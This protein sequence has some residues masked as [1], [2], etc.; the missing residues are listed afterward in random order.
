MKILKIL[1]LTLFI[2]SCVTPYHAKV[3]QNK[4]DEEK[5]TT[6]SLVLFFCEKSAPA[7]NCETNEPFGNDLNVSSLMTQIQSRLNKLSYK[8]TNSVLNPVDSELIW[9]RNRCDRLGPGLDTT[10]SSTYLSRN[11]SD[12]L[13]I[14]CVRV[15]H[16]SFKQRLGNIVIGAVFNGPDPSDLFIVSYSSLISKKGTILWWGTGDTSHW[17]G[18]IDSTYKELFNQMFGYFPKSWQS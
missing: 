6:V 17:L 2:S 8:I 14:V 7:F 3:S 16:L 10:S 9:L 18:N 1:S 5:I 11:S 15:S 4:V 13:L 12:S